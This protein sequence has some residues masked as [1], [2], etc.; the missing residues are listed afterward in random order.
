[1]YAGFQYPCTNSKHI[2]NKTVPRLG[3]RCNSDI[4]STSLHE[5]PRPPHPLPSTDWVIYRSKQTPAPGDYSFKRPYTPGGQFSNAK[6]KSDLDWTIL[7]ASQTPASDA[8]HLSKGAFSGTSGGRF[9]TAN[10]KSYLELEEYRSR[11][12]PG[13]SA[14]KPKLQKKHFPAKFNESRPKS[15]LD[16]V[17]YFSKQL[18]S[19]NRYEVRGKTRYNK[20]AA[21]GGRFT[22]SRRPS[23]IRDEIYRVS[24]HPSPGDYNVTGFRS[25]VKLKSSTVLD[26]MSPLMDQIRSLDAMTRPSTTGSGKKRRRQRRSRLQGDGSASP[27]NP[28]IAVSPIRSRRPN[29]AL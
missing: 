5:S 24:D 29:T 7:R 15:Y 10:P 18:P 6:P 12:L 9:S 19:P 23:Y 14:Y 22:G 26:P 13:P 28:G 3:V 21:G 16:W 17:E 4:L 27:S 1:L 25:S 20:A 11:P 2:P 8:Y